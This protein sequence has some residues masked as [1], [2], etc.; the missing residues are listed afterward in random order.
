MRSTRPP[1][2]ARTALLLG[3]FTAAGPIGI[4]L[5]LPAFPEIQ[6][7]LATGAN[8]IQISLVSYFVALALGQLFYGPLSDLF[9]RRGPLAIGFTI[10]LV[11][12]VGAA[13]SHSIEALIGWRFLQGLGSCAGMVIASSIARDLESGVRAARLFSLIVLV[14]G[15][16]P[17]LA[18]SMGAGLISLSPWPITFWFMAGFAIIALIVIALLMKETLS[19]TYRAANLTSAFNMYPRILADQT[20]LRAVTTG[21]FAQAGF[22]AYIAGSPHVFISLHGLSPTTYSTLFGLNAL[23]LIGSAQF[24]APLLR[25]FAPDRIIDVATAV[26]LMLAM[27]LLATTLLQADGLIVT[28]T[29]LFF[30]T[31]CLGSIAPITAMQAV[32]NHPN[33]AGAA[34]ALMGSIQF[35]AGAFAGGLLSQLADESAKPLAA[36]ILG[37]ALLAAVS[38]YL[39]MLRQ[40]TLLE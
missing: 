33:A 9:G 6:D 14:L 29:L 30:I 15:V 38:H 22:F 8:G 34:S 32:N 10:F 40:R 36:V 2:L 3:L 16:S 28:V 20:Y 23:A 39:P 27:T 26:Y 25:R 37:C 7:A 1:T 35:G 13:L 31:A 12:S 17:I 24:T 19:P 4:D 11:A 5:Y 18:P 21:A